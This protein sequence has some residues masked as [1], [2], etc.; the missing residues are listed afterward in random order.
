MQER[1]NDLGIKFRTINKHLNYLYARQRV[2]EETGHFP[3]AFM[4]WSR[5]QEIVGKASQL[6]KQKL[7]KKRSCLVEEGCQTDLSDVGKRK[8]ERGG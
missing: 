6:E 8:T 4:A 3:E 5:Q 2:C 7:E 1:S